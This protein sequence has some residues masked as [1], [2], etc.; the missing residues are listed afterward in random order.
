MSE[1]VL[2]SVLVTKCGNPN[3]F[4]YQLAFVMV[5]EC[6]IYDSETEFINPT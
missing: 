4:E 3:I 5:K 2:F 6:V 1:T